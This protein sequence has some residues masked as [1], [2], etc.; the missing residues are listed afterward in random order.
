MNL[1]GR[2]VEVCD[3]LRDVELGDGGLVQA[4]LYPGYVALHTGNHI[5]VRRKKSRNVVSIYKIL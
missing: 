5:F 4:L 2:P 3:V 1:Y